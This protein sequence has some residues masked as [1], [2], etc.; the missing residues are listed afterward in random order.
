M[1]GIIRWEQ[2]RVDVD[3]LVAAG[4][5]ERV[6][7]NYEHALRTVEQARLDLSS[8]RLLVDTN[9][10]GAFALTYDAARKALTAIL[11]N[12]GLRPPS[13]TCP[14]L[15][16][17]T[18]PRLPDGWT[19]MGQ[20]S[21]LRTVRQGSRRRSCWTAPSSSAP[22]PLRAGASRCSRSWP[23]GATRLAQRAGGCGRWPRRLRTARARSC[24]RP[25]RPAPRLDEQARFL[26]DGSRECSLRKHPVLART[27]E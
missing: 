4:R 25:G 22:T 9:P 26:L 17:S 2:G 10:V 19:G 5:V 18:A 1:P 8:A 24:V 6:T 11:A 12:Q 3:A 15:S 23:R 16:R 27:A 21:S 14:T 20:P 13:A 7:A